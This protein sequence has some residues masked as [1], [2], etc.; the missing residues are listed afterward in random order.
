MDNFCS[1][2]ILLMNKNMVIVCQNK[3]L[4]ICVFYFHQIELFDIFT[5]DFL[6][7]VSVKSISLETQTKDRCLDILFEFY[8][9]K[10][11]AIYKICATVVL[12]LKS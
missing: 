12:P 8:C 7:L 4:L 2:D 11:Q 9:A 3:F 5:S 6:M 10:G 1:C